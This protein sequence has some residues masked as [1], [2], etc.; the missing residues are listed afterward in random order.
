M[1]E[2]SQTIVLG[3]GI[4]GVSCALALQQAGRSVLLLDRRD[5][6]EE[7]SYGNSGVIS[8]GSVLPLNQPDL[9][10][11]LPTLLT[12]RTTGFRYDPAYVAMNLGWM[13]RFLLLAGDGATAERAA[14]LNGLIAPSLAAHKALMDR[15]GCRA[16]L[17]ESG[18]IKVYR[19]A[20]ALAGAARERGLYDRFGIR[21]ALLDKAALQA[22]E[23][24][25]KPVF[26]HGLHVLDT[27]SVD[28]PGDVTKAYAARFVADG[29]RFERAEIETLSPTADGGWRLSGPGATYTGAAAV[30]ALGPWS[31]PLARQ[32]GLSLPIVLERGQHL[33]ALPA[34]GARLTRPIHDVGGGYVMSPM[35]AGIRITTGVQL[36]GHGA[37][38]DLS[39]MA[40]ARAA[41]AAAVPLGPDAPVPA[42]A[43]ARPSFPDAI[44]AIG[45]HPRYPTLAVAAGHGHIGFSTGPVTGQMVAALL[46]GA[47]SPVDPSPY[48]P[49]R[50]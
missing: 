43:G 50:F 20:D 15:T 9:V 17:R 49:D 48:R 23:P 40:A 33:H 2:A 46:T 37:R 3:A 44:P 28:G 11:A 21:T 31:A 39:Q 5:P 7:T 18:W 10:K 38:P 8:R 14:A 25:L 32:T 47:P 13:A 1:T 22:A 6:G 27:A 45:L 29:G 36:A 12:N 42:W 35:S 30:L 26:A 24:D 16:L 19:S 34:D 41:A 4:V